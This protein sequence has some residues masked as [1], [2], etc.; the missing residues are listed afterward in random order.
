[1]SNSLKNN[2][3]LSLEI[4]GKWHECKEI[5]GHFKNN[6]VLI[7]DKFL[8]SNEAERLL[9]FNNL[10]L[11]PYLA[12]TQSGIIYNLLF[13]GCYFLISGE[14]E[15]KDFLYDN[16]LSCMHVNEFNLR[17]LNE[18]INYIRENSN[19][20]AKKLNIIKNKTKWEVPPFN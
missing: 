15:T 17:T 16:N 7:N 6:N 1:M 8:S 12:S 2:A 10:F 13:Y 18:R 3:Y 11:L 19:D 9:N 5:K 4:H 20:I 14:G